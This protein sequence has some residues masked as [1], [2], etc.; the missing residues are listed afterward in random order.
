MTL[1]APL[2]LVLLALIPPIVALY[3]LKLRRQDYEI[4][5]I[6]LWQ[7]F[8]RDLEA[9]AP[10]QR[11]R[12]NLLLLLQ[13]LFMLLLIL[14][15]ARPA[16]RAEGV[17][18]QSLVIVLDT[19]ASMAATDLPGQRS[20]LETAVD[21]ARDLVTNLPDDARVTLIAAAGGEA[22]LLLSA[23][24]DRGRA[25]AALADARSGTALD[26]NLDPALALAEAIVAREPEAEI[27]LISDGAVRVEAAPGGRAVRF[28]PV[29]ASGANQA[30]SA[31]SVTPG[32][33]G[34]TLFVQVRNYHDQAVQR[35]LV[36]RVDDRPFAAFDLD[37]PARGH[38]EQVV[39]LGGLP[40]GA[41]TVEAYLS[42]GEADVLA[43][44]DRAWAVLQAGEPARVTLVT[45]G[46]FYLQTALSLL[47]AHGQPLGA[48][49]ELTIAAPDSPPA[50]DA[51]L[52]IFD[53]VVPESLPAGNLLFIAPPAAVPDL[54]EVV[55][56]V[57]TPLPAVVAAEHPLL[58]NVSLAQT[59]ILSATAITP[60]PWARTLVAGQ[61]PDGETWPLLFAG[62]SAG[63]R[64]A[65]LAFQLQHSDLP[66]QPA[67]PVLVANLV[68]AASLAPGVSGLGWPLPAGIAPNQ[69][70][71]LS[72][73]PGVERVRLTRPDGRTEAVAPEAGRVT[74]G[75]AALGQP[76]LYRLA[77][78]PAPATLPGA[79][80]VLFAVNFFDPRESDVAPRADP[81]LGRAE[82]SV[83]GG[84][85][86]GRPLAAS[87]PAHR[88]WWRPLAL[89]AVAL[90]VLEWLVYHRSA[91][92]SALRGLPR[93]RFR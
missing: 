6:Y 64:V 80:T 43:L 3:L 18:G 78:E 48:N 75:G 4:S 9:N 70:V 58:E 32:A 28:I 19:S 41:R 59:Q 7:R 68:R 66:L 74:L 93:Y 37:L 15:L 50:G 86:A 92:L 27:V 8:V 73:P 38:A 71:A 5:S 34:P 22:D 35:R 60:G 40:A 72:L 63:R 49:V 29:G 36:V 69:A 20:R 79:E 88:E 1:L 89:A 11:L 76:G 61:G 53:G 90:L 21:A 14:A 57:A 24:R 25:L 26:S 62:E 81:G 47:A 67:F 87:P 23:S 56:Q 45:E 42:P 12:R 31:L 52:Y 33:E 30:I 51:T 91:L 54:F 2:A 10:W 17:A 77:F 44:D 13:V 85:T 55:G 84:S 46:N 82:P 65:V 83:D 39:P 16:T